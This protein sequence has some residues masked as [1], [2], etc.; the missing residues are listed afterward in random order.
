VQVRNL[1]RGERWIRVVFFGAAHRMQL[2]PLLLHFGRCVARTSSQGEASTSPVVRH[3]G[4]GHWTSI[5]S[6]ASIIYILYRLMPHHVFLTGRLHPMALA[7]PAV[8]AR[9]SWCFAERRLG[10]VPPC[11]LVFNAR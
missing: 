1:G 8:R 2:H 10:A 3:Y 7:A 9:A 11:L 5:T 4:T 6:L